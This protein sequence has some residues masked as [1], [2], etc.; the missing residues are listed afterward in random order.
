[1][2]NKKAPPVPRETML[3]PR[4][5]H[6]DLWDDYFTALLNEDIG[7]AR[8]A[9]PYRAAKDLEAVREIR[10]LLAELAA[11]G[12]KRSA[13][14]KA[15]VKAITKAEA[16]AEANRQ[17]IYRLQNLQ[18]ELDAVVEAAKNQ[19]IEPHL[20]EENLCARVFNR[21]HLGV[22]LRE[23]IQAAG[24]TVCPNQ[25]YILDQ[26]GKPTANGLETRPQPAPP[27]ETE[28]FE[29]TEDDAPGWWDSQNQY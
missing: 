14:E 27:I 22:L 16:A 1:M 18:F 20:I 28:A 19:R 21:R 5:I 3:D 12:C 24:L 13:R 17:E 4:E 15:A 29:E 11:F 2:A 10:R 6:A 25:G 8:L 23:E 7:L 26:N 9:A